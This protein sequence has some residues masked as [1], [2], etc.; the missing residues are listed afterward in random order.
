MPEIDEREKDAAFA[1]AQVSPWSTRE[2]VGRALWMLVRGSLFRYSWH[3]WYGWRRWLLRLFGAKL[4]EHTMT[5]P[6]TLVEI[7]WLLTI[8]DYSSL[9][10]GT[11]IYNLGPVT[12]GRRV[13]ISQYAHLCAGSHDFSRWSMTLLRPPITVGDDAWVA[14]EAFVAPGVNIGAGA[15]LGARAC[16]YRDLKPW[17]IYAGHPAQ[18]LRPRPPMQADALSDRAEVAP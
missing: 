1:S 2:K 15:I 13:T 10:D 9:G 12:I 14:A 11:I 5:R 17:T 8:G 16:A 18:A 4:G 6:T 7:P 3:N